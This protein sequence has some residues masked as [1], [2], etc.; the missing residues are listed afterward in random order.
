MEHLTVDL[1]IT[2]G[3]VRLANPILTASGTF[4]YGAEFESFGDLSALGGLVTKGLTLEARPGNPPRRIA[5]TPGGMLNSIGLQNVGVE[6]FL[7]EKLPYLRK[8]GTRVIV[9]LNGRTPAEYVELA[10]C[11]D[12]AEGVDGLELNVS[13]PNVEKGGREFGTDPGILYSLVYD[14]RQAT[15]L[16]LWVKL[17]P[18][19]TDLAALARSCEAGGAD[20]IVAINTLTAAHVRPVWEGARL[21]A[22]VLRGGLSGPAVKP[23]ALRAVWEIRQAVKIPIVGVG[24]VASADDVLEFLAVG[25]QAVQVGTASFYDPSLAM[26]LPAD[27]ERLLADRGV[28]RLEDLVRGILALEQAT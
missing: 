16:P 6:A 17:S 14:V 5:E 7:A 15:R 20:A 11:L 13:C 2:V 12:G 18:S 1:G 28:T 4:G 21:R 10:A 23:V 24:G 8:A 9:N 19:V 27:L 26:R 22:D 25:A 3:R